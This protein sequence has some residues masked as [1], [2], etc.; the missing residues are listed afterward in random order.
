MLFSFRF[1]QFSFQ[2]QFRFLCCSWLSLCF[3]LCQSRDWLRRSFPNWTELNSSLLFRLIFFY[4]EIKAKRVIWSRFNS[5]RALVLPER[6]H[7]WCDVLYC[8]WYCGEQVGWTEPHWVT[9][10]YAQPVM[11][12]VMMTASQ[13]KVINSSCEPRQWLLLLLLSRLLLRGSGNW[14]TISAVCDDHLLM[15]VDWILLLYF[16]LSQC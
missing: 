13:L 14:H 11:L 16:F 2:F 9:V 1:F 3:V 4:I 7:R 15:S 8:W 6:H 10:V 5:N 12:T